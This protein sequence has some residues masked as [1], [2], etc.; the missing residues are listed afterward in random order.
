MTPHFADRYQFGGDRMKKLAAVV[1]SAGIL[2]SATS[3][4][5]LVK[6]D[7]DQFD[8]P[9][10]VGNLV[11]NEAPKSVAVLSSNLADVVLACGYEGMLAARG[12]VCDQGALEIL[13]TVGTAQEPDLDELEDLGV[14]LILT[15]ATFSEETAE[16]LEKLGISALVMKPADDIEALSKL[17]NNVAASLAGGY[18]GKM[19]AMSVF[20]DLKGSL[21]TVRS[22]ASSDNIVSTTCY[23]YDVTEDECT[24][25][26]G[27]DFA[28]QLFD[29]ASLTNITAADDDGIVG[30][31]T[32]LKGNPDS[33]FCDNGVYEKLTANKDLKSLRALSKSAVYVLPKKYLEMQGTTC[34]KTADYIAAKTHQNYAQS[35]PWPDEFDVVEEAAEYVAP[36]EP[37]VDIYYTIGESY[38]PI[39]D[40][41]ER[42]ISLGYMQGKADTAYDQDTA[43]AISSFQ[44][45]NGLSATGVADYATLKILLSNDAKSRKEAGEVTYTPE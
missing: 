17:Y 41:E 23:I 38:E 21:E 18:T 14:D 35:Q 12:E 9:V 25:A 29:Y 36:F 27:G 40:I 33:I 15:D 34:L 1:L 30:I 6:N 2:V 4:N 20:E 10:T 45:S 44:S 7:E 13:P 3:C 22:N 8:Y 42:L 11:F 37:Q 39:K 5:M 16:Q 43:D 31:D 28:N 24:V 26:Y 32:L 19:Q